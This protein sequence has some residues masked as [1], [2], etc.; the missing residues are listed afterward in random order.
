MADE[1]A[2]GPAP[3][4]PAEAW[5]GVH[6]GPLREGEWVRLTDAKGRRHNICLEAGRRFFSNKGHLEHDA[7]IGREEGFAVTSSAGGQYLVFRPL[8]SEFV[9]SMPRGAAVVYPKDAAQ[10]VAMADIFPG[11]DVVE[12]G[13]GSGALTCSLLRAVGPHGRVLSY[14]RREEF[15]DVARANVR[16]FFSGDHPAWQLTLGDLAEELPA[17]GERVDR[18][19]LDMLAP[20]ECV[21]AAADA[22]RP[23]GIICGYVATTTQLSRLVETLRAH[24]T[25][26]EPAVWESLVR[27][28]HVEGLAVRPGHKMQGHTAF[29]VTARRMAPGE[30]P[31][32]RKRRPAPGAYGPD[33]TGPRPADVPPPDPTEASED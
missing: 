29:L 16:Q 13:V 4:V 24:G 20:W 15:A 8:L 27:D 23:G 31:P 7:L 26:T 19:I 11:A 18:V 6:R 2:T 32:A 5:S 10:I 28:W 14:E 25:F 9:V 12:A 21:E 3:D 30:R 17:S 22:L 33:Y 1:T